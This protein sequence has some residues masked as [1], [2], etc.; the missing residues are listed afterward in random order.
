MKEKTK[1]I[2]RGIFIGSMILM[3][4]CAIALY[5]PFIPAIDT[6]FPG[7]EN[8]FNVLFP[9]IVLLLL[10]FLI[11]ICVIKI[12]FNINNEEMFRK[13]RVVITKKQLVGLIVLILAIWLAAS[14]FVCLREGGINEDSL[15]Y[16]IVPLIVVPAVNIP[17]IVRE[18]R[19]NK[20]D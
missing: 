7:I 11:V 2:L 19:E 17:A 18:Y 8:L 1:K 3:A 15:I 9:V 16:L 6:V 12:I 20:K 4:V 13:K 10:A 5:V 14:V